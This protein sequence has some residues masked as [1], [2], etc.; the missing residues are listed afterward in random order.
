MVVR[1]APGAP[2]LVQ[3]DPNRLRQVLTNLLNNAAKFTT[4]GHIYLNVEPTGGHDET[5]NLRF[6]IKDTGIGIKKE[7][8]DSIFE[9]FTQ[10]D[11]STTRRFG[12]TGLGLPI[13]QHLVSLMGGKISAD[14]IPGEGATFSF[15]LPLKAVEPEL[16]PTEALK[17]HDERILVVTKHMLGG[18]VLAEQVRHLGYECSVAMGCEDAMDLLPAPPGKSEWSFVLVDQDVVQAEIPRIKEHLDKL[19][20]EFGTKLIMLTALSSTVREKDLVLR[21]FSG[22][23]PKPVRPHQLRAVLEGKTTT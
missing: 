9:K 5:I 3:C 21:G 8:L 20:Q 23:L 12:G 14:S 17:E 19:G 18:E 7:K 16:D 22:T 11:A 13:S 6:E 10:A 1:I 2:D 4:E 15:T